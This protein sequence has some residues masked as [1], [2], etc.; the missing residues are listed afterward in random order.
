MSSVC[1][2]LDSLCLFSMLLTILRKDNDVAAFPCNW[3]GQASETIKVSFALVN[4][5]L[6]NISL[7]WLVCCLVTVG[8]R[9]N[10][11]L[12]MWNKCTVVILTKTMARAGVQ[13]TASRIMEMRAFSSLYIIWKHMLVCLSHTHRLRKGKVFW[14]RNPHPLVINKPFKWCRLTQFTY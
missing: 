14:A 11:W 13:E 8:M 7:S 6:Y 12:W 3:Q 10:T 2:H 1:C 4:K 5:I 9:F